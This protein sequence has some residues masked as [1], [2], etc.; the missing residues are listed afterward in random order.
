MTTAFEKVINK[1]LFFPFDF[2]SISSGLNYPTVATKHK[3]TKKVVIVLSASL[4]VVTVSA[5][6]LLV[7]YS[8]LYEKYS[9]K[10]GYV[11]ESPTEIQPGSTGKDHPSFFTG[12]I[13]NNYED[14]KEDY[15]LQNN[16]RGEE[17]YIVD[18][19]KTI[20]G[21]REYRITGLDI[22]DEVD[23]NGNTKH[24]YYS[25][26][27]YIEECIL[28]FRCDFYY[29]E[30]NKTSGNHVNY[31]IL[32]MNKTKDIL[33]DELHYEKFD[34]EKHGAYIPIKLSADKTDLSFILFSGD[35][36]IMYIQFFGFPTREEYEASY[37]GTKIE[38]NLDYVL[39]QR[40][41]I[42]DEIMKLYKEEY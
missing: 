18:T 6:L 9:N 24:H 5:T 1:N 23:N 20:V 34:I 41:T 12:N 16:I 30:A 4:S 33:M 25:N 8:Y 42:L 40:D 11:P 31:L 37:D 26:R 14:F 27:V 32:F 28:P 15:I 7:Q 19:S 13:F 29:P 10:G 36:K 22:C 2:S 21:Q 17:A 39:E 35:E 3:K 38:Q